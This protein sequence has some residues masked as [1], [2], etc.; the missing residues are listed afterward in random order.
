[1]VRLR[2]LYERLNEK[3]RSKLLQIFI[4]RMIVD[5]Q[6]KIIDFQLNAPFAYLQHIV[7]DLSNL[8]SVP[9][10]S[11]QVLVGAPNISYPEPYNVPV[12]QV[13]AMLRFR[14]R[15]K[16]AELPINLEGS[17]RDDFVYSSN[18]FPRMNFRDTHQLPGASAGKCRIS[19]L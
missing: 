2:V 1:M 3:E 7:E 14:Q 11:T 5:P 18:C 15:S 17:V 8:D 10:G 16:L 9:R 13:L 6:G 19:F 12:E 4:K